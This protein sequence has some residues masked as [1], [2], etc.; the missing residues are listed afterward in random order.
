M[1]LGPMDGPAAARQTRGDALA[2]AH[3]PDPYAVAND[4]L[5]H[6]AGGAAGVPAWGWVLIGAAVLLFVLLVLWLA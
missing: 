4:A 1:S 3:A 5:L 6:E 2:A